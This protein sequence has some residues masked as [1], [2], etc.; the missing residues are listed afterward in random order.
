MKVLHL[1]YTSLPEKSGS[2]IRSHSILK[3][4]K[5]N[6]IDVSILVAPFVKNVTL[7]KTYCFEGV[8][9]KLMK[10]NQ[11]T[12]SED[13]SGIKQIFSKAISIFLFYNLV[14][15][16]IKK[17]KP[18]I[19]HSHSMFYCAFVGSLISA[20]YKIP[21][22][23][24]IRSFWELRTMSKSRIK[25]QIYRLME[26]LAILFA[27]KLVVISSS[28]KYDIKN[29]W[30]A[31]KKKKIEIIYN[32]LNTKN[33]KLSNKIINDFK[34]NKP[35]RL[36]YIGNISSIEGL[37]RVIHLINTKSS[38]NKF[39]L[40]IHGFGSYEKKLQE[41]VRLNS[42]QNIFFHGEFE[43]S[44]L[45][46]IYNDIDIVVI[47][48]IPIEICEKVTPLKPLE[49]IINKKPV[50]CSNVN[51]ILELFDYKTDL[52][53]FFDKNKDDS[54]LKTLNKCLTLN[55]KELGDQNKK[56]I[57]FIKANRC[58]DANT[59]KYKEIYGFKN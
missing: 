9:Y 17:N 14:K 1:L 10:S 3:S 13:V 50:I 23:Y 56:A 47:A 11:Y 26:N 15:K 41:I 45:R 32:S 30:A 7:N 20:L 37:D 53:Y 24:E 49:A 5:E 28:M 27:N 40:H 4:Q 55:K 16:E 31:F 42:Y 57:N 43:R 52:I 58:W 2:S 44:E 48:R 21:H 46:T 51:G 19:I 33:I 25:F 18:D 54:L 8:S 36:G 59:K 34:F 22:V 35:L 6:G 39:E 12:K 29:R 38:K